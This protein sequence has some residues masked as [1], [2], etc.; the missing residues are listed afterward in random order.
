MKVSIRQTKGA[1]ATAEVPA[2]ALVGSIVGRLVGVRRLSMRVSA[3]AAAPHAELVIERRDRVVAYRLRG[4]LLRWTHAAAT[5]VAAR[6]LPG[7]A[8]VAA[9]VGG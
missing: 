3:D 8:A 1:R 6:V 7:G 5:R 2:L 9:P 4:A